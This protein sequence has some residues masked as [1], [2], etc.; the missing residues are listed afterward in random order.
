[1]MSRIP[2]THLQRIIFVAETHLIEMLIF[3]CIVLAKFRKQTLMS[4]D[5]TRSIKLN[6]S[7]KLLSKTITE[8]TKKHLFQISI[9]Y[10]SVVY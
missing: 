6:I 5:Y 7:N 8:L 2:L 10:F 1:M 3:V 4:I 9:C